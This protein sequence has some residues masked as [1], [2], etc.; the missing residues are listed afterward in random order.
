MYKG[1]RARD[2]KGEELPVVKSENGL[3]SVVIGD[4]TGDIQVRYEE[5]L[6]QKISDGITFLTLLGLA[7]GYGMVT[8]RKRVKKEKK[9]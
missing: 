7:G 6:V 4:S 3:V 5:T 2:V 1:Y 8:Y 9:I